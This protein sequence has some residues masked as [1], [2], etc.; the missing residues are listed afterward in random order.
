IL[1]QY[2]FQESLVGN[3]LMESWK[4]QAGRAKPRHLK[5]LYGFRSDPKKLQETVAKL[6]ALHHPGLVPN[7]VVHVDKGPVVL[8]SD[9][10]KETVRDRFQKCLG[11][12]LPGI[13]RAE[14]VDYL[15]AAAEVLDYLYQ[16]HGLQHLG[17]N[18]RSFVLDHGW[19]QVH[20]FGL[21]QLL[22]LPAGQ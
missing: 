6:K 14:L 4:V 12:K 13:P 15:R 21:N 19:L 8:L 17:L 11:L 10:V 3:P 5:V 20:D 18:P 2:H 9:L 7:E 1:E 22:W 16:Q